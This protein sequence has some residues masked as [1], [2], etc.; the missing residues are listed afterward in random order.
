[1]QA[2]ETAK[3]PKGRA[4][5]PPRE[6]AGEVEQRILDAAREVFLS[7][8][9]EG[10]S[11]DE[12]AQVARAGKPTIYA[13]FEGKEALYAAVVAR[14]V[15]TNTRVENFGFT[16]D[17]FEERLVNLAVALL[18]SALNENTVG[19]IRVSISEARRLPE[20]TQRVTEMARSHGA[21]ALARLLNEVVQR[22]GHA[23]GIFAADR[24]AATARIFMELVFFPLV[25]RALT[26]EE[27]G[28]LRREIPAHVAERVA[29]FLAASARDGSR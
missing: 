21:E 7:R 13:R 26:G 2:A 10:A 18:E 14:N 28:V 23:E 29:F 3:R 16:G 27:L 15:E 25:F 1:M 17:S 5:R 9:F 24:I 4:G 22:E 6:R 20:L 19:L 11:I 12:I 8:G